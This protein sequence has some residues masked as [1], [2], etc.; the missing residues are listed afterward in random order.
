[1]TA[2]VEAAREGADLPRWDLSVLFPGLESPEFDAAFTRLV[3]D[4]GRLRDQFDA[5]GVGAGAR[6]AFSEALVSE[7]DAVLAA[8]NDLEC[9]LD[10]MFA[11]LYGFVT[12][13][14]R[15]EL[16]QARYSA[17]RER[18][19]AFSKL[20][21]RFTAWV[22]ALPLDAL[23]AASSCAAEHAFPLQR[24]QIAAAHLMSEP[25]ESLAAEMA[26]SAG[27]AWGRLHG[28][29]TSQISAP[30]DL[31]GEARRLPMSEIRN[32]AMDPDRGV[33]RRAWEAELA[34]WEAHEVPL[35]AAL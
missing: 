32:L 28:N 26:P 27:S 2:E 31:D 17:L 6:I 23:I 1:M 29:L 5:A 7:F 11:Y 24:L 20:Q 30:V 21:T 9:R 13:D 14:S 4:V 22:G 3:E 33:R 25:E 34:A 18:M 15:N 16:A 35:A 19:V 8:L 12:T 10:S